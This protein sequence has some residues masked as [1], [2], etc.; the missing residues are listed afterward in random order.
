MGK[1]YSACSNIFFQIFLLTF[2]FSLNIHPQVIA[3]SDNWKEPGFT[4]DAQSSSGVEIN[5][6]INEFSINDI[7]ING[8]QMKKIDL[9]GVFLPNDEGLPD[10]PGS[11]RY[12]ALPHSADANFEIVSF[13]T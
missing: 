8:V 5:F 2:L 9:P 13:R 6:S 3:Y 12:I 4:L 11:G 1:I 10:L 7:E